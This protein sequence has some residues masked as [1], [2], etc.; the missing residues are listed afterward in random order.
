[1]GEEEGRAFKSQRLGKT[2]TKQCPVEMTGP[3]YSWTY[4]SCHFLHKTCSWSSQSTFLSWNRKGFM[5]LHPQLESYE[6]LMSY[7]EGTHV[8]MGVAPVDETP[9]SGC[10]QIHEC[11][12]STQ[13]TWWVRFLEKRHKVFLCREVEMDL[14]VVRG[15]SWRWLWSKHI[16]W[17]SQI[18]NKN[19]YNSFYYHI[20]YYR[21]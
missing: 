20:A 1:M 6:Q 15:R 14:R 19:I 18:I 3:M 4:I 12:D 8:F 10:P 5:S 16:L 17:S 7:G 13:W 11:V 2:G 21:T 9:S